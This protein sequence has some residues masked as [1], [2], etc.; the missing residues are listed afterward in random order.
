[1][2]GRSEWCI[3]R[4]RS[5]GVP[6]PAL[7][8][9]TSE[10]LLTAESLA[11]ILPILAKNGT[12]YWWTAPVEEFLPPS[13][14]GSSEKW[15]KGSDTMDVWFDSGSA[16]TMLP[17]RAGPAA[18][19]KPRADVV[20]EGSD[21]HRGWFQSLLLTC[22]A[23]A[24]VAAG[25]TPKAPYGTVITHGFT[26]DEQNDK[27]SKSEGNVVSPLD[28]INGTQEGDKVSAAG[29]SPRNHILR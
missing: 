12:S 3:S 1:M 19:S 24:D 11:H 8:S 20:L 14:Q 13:L 26:L 16:W 9:S 2:L 4:Q 6:I 23:S 18:S 5:W 25:V 7:Y 21:Q 22:V 27:M 10:P 15:T 17:D 29:L 28:V